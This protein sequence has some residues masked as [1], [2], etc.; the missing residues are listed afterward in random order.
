MQRHIDDAMS[1]YANIVIGHEWLASRVSFLSTAFV[2][3][4]AYSSIYTD[5]S[6][7][8]T[9]LAITLALKLKHS[10]ELAIGQINVTRTGFNAVDRV[11]TLAQV[12]VESNQGKSAPQGWPCGGAIAVE[13]LVVRFENTPLDALKGVSFSA[14]PGERVGIVGRTG[15]GKTS[16]ANALLQFVPVAKGTITV[17][18]QD[19]SRIKLTDLRKAIRIIPQDPCLFSGS[20]RQNIDPN[21]KYSDEKL[22]SALVRIRFDKLENSGAV[23]DMQIHRGGSNLSHGQRQLLCLTRMLLEDDCC[24]LILDEATSGIDSTTDAVIQDIIREGFLKTTVVV[25]AHRIAT[26]ADFD[27]IL[28]LSEGQLAENGSPKELM[29]NKGQFY[30]MVQRSEGSEHIRSIVQ[31]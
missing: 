30:D 8:A 26:V 11:L 6:A 20:L 15:A 31:K 18:G 25:I 17:D 28:V 13:N 10:L 16:L 19:I 23:L 27:Q 24:I 29:D 3:L 5:R 9:G 2:S 1:V 7:A 21:S 12:P 4:I 14:K 22:M